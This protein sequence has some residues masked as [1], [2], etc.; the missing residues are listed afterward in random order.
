MPHSR[1]TFTHK[2]TSPWKDKLTRRGQWKTNVSGLSWLERQFYSLISL[3]NY[4][5]LL[6]LCEYFC[7]NRPIL[8]LFLREL[9][10]YSGFIQPP[11]L[12]LICDENGCAPIFVLEA[13]AGVPAHGLCTLGA[14]EPLGCCGEE[15]RRHTAGVR[16][17][18]LQHRQ[19]TADT[20]LR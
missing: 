4:E 17:D 18:G 9:T 2:N 8:H 16:R 13:V 15:L 20:D 1:S 11:S 14:P 12:L 3:G 10:L 19:R 7:L 5:F 6:I